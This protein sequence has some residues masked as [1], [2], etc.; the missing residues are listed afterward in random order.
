VHDATD[1]PNRGVYRLGRVHCVLHCV[2]PQMRNGKEI[3]RRATV[4]VLKNTGSAEVE[5]I[6]RDIKI[7]PL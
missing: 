3:V 6:L 4:A 1:I 2:H 7:A 5:Y